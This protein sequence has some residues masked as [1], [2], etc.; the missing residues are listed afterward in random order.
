M[1]QQSLRNLCL[2]NIESSLLIPTS[3]Q[4]DQSLLGALQVVSAPMLHAERER[5]QSDCMDAQPDCSFCM[6]YMSVSRYEPRHD[7]TN[8]LTCV[9]SEDSDQPV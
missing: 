7:K 3:K 6:V 5:L 4:A 1:A 8:K 9:P 2:L